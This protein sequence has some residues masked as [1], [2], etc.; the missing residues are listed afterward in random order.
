MAK[1]KEISQ[2]ILDLK[3][4]LEDNKVILGTKHTL[5]S[6][7]DGILGKVYLSNN[8]PKAVR[9]D[10]VYN[11]G[12]ANLPVVILKLDNEE[13]GSLCKKQFFVSVL[14]VKR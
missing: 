8:C 10:V 2:E 5:K 13:I 4:E 7:K 9:D 3:K 11:A 6:L 14:G 1:K 12:L